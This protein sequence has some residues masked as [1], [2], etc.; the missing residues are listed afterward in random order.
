MDEGPGATRDAEKMPGYW[1][2]LTIFYEDRPSYEA[3]TQ[4]RYVDTP[5][6]LVETV[7]TQAEAD[8]LRRMI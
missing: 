1:T 8:E 6:G 5:V 2:G 7:V 3:R 4:V